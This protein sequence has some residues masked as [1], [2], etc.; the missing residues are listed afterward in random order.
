MVKTSRSF[1]TA[2]PFPGEVH[3]DLLWLDQMM[4]CVISDTSPLAFLSKSWQEGFV[5]AATTNRQ[6]VHR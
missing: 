6:Q 3:G 5:A 1:P 2:N 4:A